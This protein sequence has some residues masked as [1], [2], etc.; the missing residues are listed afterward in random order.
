MGLD[1][2]ELVMEVEDRFNIRIPDADAAHVRTVGDLSALAV[3]HVRR[4]ESAVCPTAAQFYRIRR[5]LSGIGAWREGA[6]PT[7]PIAIAFLAR[8][9]KIRHLLG[10]DGQRAP[11]LDRSAV[12]GI[13]YAIAATTLLLGFFAFGFA[14]IMLLG[15]TAVLPVFWL[16]VIMSI[17]IVALSRRTRT[18][19]P[20]SIATV[21]DLVHATMPTLPAGNPTE[22]AV[23]FEV[24][25]LT[26]EYFGVPIESITEHT[27]FVRD[28]GMD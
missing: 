2:V 16:G 24:R 5:S 13:A 27:N 1:G 25:R 12:S 18:W 3:R 11:R 19:W 17:G 26:A 21:G 22:S 9:R 10:E 6:R 23:Q 4:C 20:K 28:L 14:L 15:W 7:T 8:P